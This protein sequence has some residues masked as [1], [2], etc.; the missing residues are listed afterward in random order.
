MI[1]LC[2]NFD[3]TVST[4]GGELHKR[5]RSAHRTRVGPPSVLAV[6]SFAAP[7]FVGCGQQQVGPTWAREAET[8]PAAAVAAA[9][10]A[11]VMGGSVE[12]VEEQL[13]L[14]VLAAK[15]AL[16]LQRV[17][18]VYH[19]SHLHQGSV[20]LLTLPVPVATTETTR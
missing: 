16:L 17:L 14:A 19:R 5:R 18:R 4:S 10:A 11:V 8:A 6:G 7:N 3:P 2:Q 12:L 9:A 20:A 15:R 13:E 1:T